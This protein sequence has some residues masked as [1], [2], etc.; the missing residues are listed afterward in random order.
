VRP[1]P[2]LIAFIEKYWHTHSQ[3]PTRGLL[4]ATF[5]LSPE[6]LEKVL[7]SQNFQ[8]SMKNRGIPWDR[9]L[10]E[11]SPI[12]IAAAQ[13]VAN[14]VDNRNLASVLA[15]MGI[16]T[17]TYQGWLRN[18]HFRS[19]LQVLTD[20]ILQTVRPEARV[21]F[22]KK[23]SQG[24]M[25]ALVK[26]M[27]M[28]G[29]FN[30]HSEELT[31]LRFVIQGLVESVQRNVKDRE[32]VAA[33]AADFIQLQPALSKLPIGASPVNDY[34]PEAIV[35]YEDKAEEAPVGNNY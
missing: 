21:Q 27:E 32:T 6:E 7:R 15:D 31:N 9:D 11:L 20:D 3:V 29:E 1:A 23:V 24:N 35:N 8:V 12:Q 19:Y 33:I 26:Y 4:S 22:A 14:H 13:A 2:K 10:N 17:A 28:T 18:P 34:E 16:K 25:T 5:D 30:Q